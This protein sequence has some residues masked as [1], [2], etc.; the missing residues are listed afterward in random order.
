MKE[1]EK[2]SQALTE[3]SDTHIDEAAEPRPGKS[4]IWLRITAL[5]AVAALVIAIVQTQ[6]PSEVS[7]D[8]LVSQAGAC[9]ESQM[10]NR[11]DYDSAEAYRADLD[12]WYRE[13]TQRSETVTAALEQLSDFFAAG[14]SQFLTDGGENAAWS[15]VNAYIGLAM[16]AELTD[17]NSRQQILS[18]FGVDSIEA[19]RSQTSTIWE[20]T[21]TYKDG[22]EACTLANS[23]W[24]QQGLQFR[25]EVMDDLAYHYYASVYQ[26]DLSNAGTAI[27]NWLRENTGN[28]LKN[29]NVALP[30]NTILALYSTIYFQSRWVESF[31]AAANTK[32]V[33]HAPGGD[34]T[35]T[36]MNKSQEILTYHYGENFSA[37][38]L[39][40]KNGSKMWLILPDDG[41]SPAD[42]LADGEYMDMLLH[43]QWEN[44]KTVR[45][46]L[47]MPKFDISGSSNLAS[48][49]KQMGLTDI[50]DSEK[51]DFSAAFPQN[52]V[53]FT[54][55]NQT[56]RVQVDEEGIKAAAYFEMPCAT[57][58]EP[59][60]DI[61]DFVLNR[62][63]LFV[64]SSS[65]I[66][67]FTGVVTNP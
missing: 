24:L 47:S 39:S 16:A 20:S 22:P 2:I 34:K 63:F 30:D 62:P 12:L 17:G 36:Y 11:D 8:M 44:C 58:P 52:G 7:A 38:A 49:L 1:H 18:L 35:V 41:Y 43:R 23:L 50:F 51:A 60:D 29:Y 64:I 46:N 15:P 61:V 40:L 67:L 42:V 55:A 53:F 28:L 66:P 31:N 33:F 5:A 19:L 6:L 3:I 32:D 54:A 9:R 37:V 25:Q 56:L 27:S 57:A 10:P 48:G 59:P 4:R 13:Q 21:Y 45:V 14:N 65:D 26:T